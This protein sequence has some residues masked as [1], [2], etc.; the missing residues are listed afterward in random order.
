MPLVDDLEVPVI[1]EE[2]ERRRFLGLLGSGAL[3]LAGLGTVI[4]GIRYLEPDVLYEEDERFAVGRPEAIPV[5]TLLVAR[6]R[7]VYVIHG[8]AGFYAISAV[9]SHFG[10]VTRHAPGQDRIVCPC[11]GSSFD[12]AGNVTS[13]P[14]PSGLVHLKLTLEDGLLIADVGCPVPADT[15][16]E[17]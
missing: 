3:G 16:L 9:C 4:A 8:P 7:K 10:C 15:V 11:H 1:G 12:L 2:L 14:A 17:V 6:A 5:G 13:G